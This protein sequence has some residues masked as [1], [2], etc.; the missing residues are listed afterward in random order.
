MMTDYFVLE[1]PGAKNRR[2]P[3]SDDR[4]ASGGRGSFVLGPL[5]HSNFG[6]WG[7]FNNSIND[8]KSFSP[9]GETEDP[10]PEE[11][12]SNDMESSNPTEQT[13]VP[14]LPVS[15]REV[16]KVNLY[17]QKQPTVIFEA[18]A[19]DGE[20]DFLVSPIDFTSPVTSSMNKYNKFRKSEPTRSIKRSVSDMGSFR[21]K[22]DTFQAKEDTTDSFERSP[23][24]DSPT[25][26]ASP[27]LRDMWRD[28]KGSEMSLSFSQRRTPFSNRALLNQIGQRRN[29]YRNLFDDHE[30][31]QNPSQRQ[32]LLKQIGQRKK[33]YRNLFNE[34]E[35]DEDNDDEPQQLEQDQSGGDDDETFEGTM[36]LKTSTS[37]VV[38]KRSSSKDRLT[39][40]SASRPS[41]QRSEDSMMDEHGHRQPTRKSSVGS[42]SN[43][44]KSSASKSSRPK[45][46]ARSLSDS[47]RS[48]KSSKSSERKSRQKEETTEDGSSTMSQDQ[49]RESLL[50]D[51][52]RARNSRR[53]AA[54]K[55]TVAPERQSLLADVRRSK[56]SKS[57]ARRS[58]S[59]N[60]I[61]DGNSGK[62]GQPKKPLSS[63]SIGVSEEFNKYAS[64]TKNRRF[65][66]RRT[67]MT[68]NIIDTEDE[69]QKEK[70]RSSMGNLTKSPKVRARERRRATMD[71]FSPS[72]DSPLEIPKQSK[73]KRSMT[74]RTNDSVESSP[75]VPPRPPFEDETEE[76]GADSFRVIRSINAQTND[77]PRPA[78]VSRKSSTGSRNSRTPR[79]PKSS[80]DMHSQESSHI[81]R[82]KAS[83]TKSDLGKQRQR[84]STQNQRQQ[85]PQELDKA[86]TVAEI[87]ALC[88][89]SHSPAEV[90]S[91]A[92]PRLGAKIKRSKSMDSSIDR[93]SRTSGSGSG[94]AS[95][96]SHSTG[97]PKESR[98]RIRGRSTDKGT[99][100]SKRNSRSRSAEDLSVEDLSGKNRER[101]RSRSNDK[102]DKKAPREKSREKNR[103]K[104][105]SRSRNKEIQRT[106][107]FNKLR[108]GKRTDHQS[109]EP[110]PQDSPRKKERKALKESRHRI[111]GRRVSAK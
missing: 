57:G 14:R 62:S 30:E 51:V 25:R 39:K 81:I 93:L 34:V 22:E 71:H 75:K 19:L 90:D 38:K 101:N 8:A 9:N 88:S 79:K 67:S 27:S 35:V 10:F 72:I 63:E 46:R 95:T 1:S 50:A 96:C 87:L 61:K 31:D 108:K 104:S 74:S 78:I 111:G 66:G 24:K 80:G 102:K 97:D 54:K 56:T 59:K 42:I 6:D 28:Q 47:N 110:P 98:E 85:E 7:S 99:P 58:S 45:T 43:G 83:R 40:K 20:S 12:E 17:E 94:T 52:R 82:R 92:L 2:A 69:N 103:E 109:E 77:Q 5:N 37:S 70:R 86:V 21:I 106:S 18:G 89:S 55:I 91:E 76:E 107:S 41:S 65:V 4:D 68:G 3:I 15:K 49:E 29:S 32:S 33:S 23:I 26:L 48:S 64:K 16:R 11:K 36:P 73:S 100:R 105:R 13:S 84:F 60:K 53:N 44:S